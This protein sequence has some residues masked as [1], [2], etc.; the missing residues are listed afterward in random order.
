MK[1]ILAILL[2]ALAGCT[3]PVNETAAPEMPEPA[4]ATPARDPLEL[5]TDVDIVVLHG[6]TL[7]VNGTVTPGA[8]V[9]VAYLDLAPT[10]TVDNGTWSVTVKPDFGHTL[11]NITADDGVETTTQSVL[12]KRHMLLTVNINHDPAQGKQDRSDDIYWDHGGLRSLHE[13]ASYQDCEQPHPGR[14]N[15]HDALLDYVDIT[16]VNIDFSD[17]GSFGVSPSNIDDIDYGPLGWCF[18][19]NGEAADFGISLLE[20]QDGDVFEFVNCSGFA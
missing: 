9:D 4:P 10:V 7:T 15:A 13:D 12:I 11:L 16:G 18:N 19:V 17:C 2:L 6:D 3:E 8:L 14:P 5:T 20:L 1:A